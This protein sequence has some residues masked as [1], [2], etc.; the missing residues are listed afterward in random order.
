MTGLILC[1]GNSSRMGSDKGLLSVSG[2]TW[3]ETAYSKLA[4]VIASVIISV[5]EQQL[6]V[7]RSH[8][9]DRTLI[10]DNPQLFVG[11]PL[12]GLLSAHLLLPQEDI[13]VFACDLLFMENIVF[14][15]L[16]DKQQQSPANEAYVFMNNQQAEPLCGMYTAKGL[17][18]IFTAYHDGSLGKQSMK[19]VLEM[20]NTCYLP[21][22]SAWQ[23]Y[24]KNINTRY[25]L[26]HE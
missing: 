16:L 6:P 18:K 14:R 8:F 13:F 17:A 24:F 12:R 22:P 4:S 15:N 11:G 1:G 2:I 10:V 3:A 25:D 23:D 26:G 7:Y 19:H 5:N 21:L 20:L 9:A